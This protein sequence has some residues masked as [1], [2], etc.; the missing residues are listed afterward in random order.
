MTC[1]HVASLPAEVTPS[2]TEG[3]ADCLAAG[4]HDWVHLRMCLSCGHVG[5]CDSSPA[6]HAT[7]HYNAERHPIVQSREPGEDWRWC[8]ADEAIV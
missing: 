4:R 3:C 8:Y 6:K 2:T 7:A 1:P 5:C